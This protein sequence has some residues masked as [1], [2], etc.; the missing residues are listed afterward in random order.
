MRVRKSLIHIDLQMFAYSPAIFDS[1]CISGAQMSDATIYTMQQPHPTRQSTFKPIIKGSAKKKVRIGL[2]ESC[3][4][5]NT[6][7]PSTSCFKEATTRTNNQTKPH[8]TISHLLNRKLLDEV[9]EEVSNAT[10]KILYQTN[11]K[12]LPLLSALLDWWVVT[13]ILKCKCS[14]LLNI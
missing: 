5:S 13:Y 12:Y 1:T 4:L 6:Y 10:H 3:W 14:Q 7:S 2:L 8:T 11:T 9:V